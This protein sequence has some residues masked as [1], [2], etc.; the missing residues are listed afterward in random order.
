MEKTYKFDPA[1]K[2]EVKEGG[3]KHIALE[4]D[5]G[6]RICNYNPAKTKIDTKW[7]EMQRRLKYQPD[8]RYKLLCNMALGGKN[9][10]DVFIFTKGKVD[11]LS[12][13]EPA[14]KEKEIVY[15]QSNEKGSRT[16]KLLS[17]EQALENIKEVEK[18]RGENAILKAEIERLKI[19]ISELESEPLDETQPNKGIGDFLN[20][21]V[22]TVVPILE[23]FLDQRDKQLSLQ[24]RK[25]GMSR[26]QKKVIRRHVRQNQNDQ[27]THMNLDIN[28]ADHLNA[29]YDE[30]DQMSDP[31]FD[32]AFQMIEADRPEL[33]DL[34]AEEFQM[35]EEEEQQ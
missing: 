6:E 27:L 26:P 17:M 29:L 11:D 28:N 3:Y 19:E 32:A 31:D 9:K 7:D 4:S 2:R 12:E 23:R 1:L 15:V 20:D 8:G 22:P 33:A 34:I 21:T 25:L 10:P 14:Q 30:L 16:E 5:T 13:R 24:E 35:D 18:L